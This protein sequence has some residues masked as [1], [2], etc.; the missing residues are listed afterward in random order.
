MIISIENQKGGV[1]KTTIAIHIAQAL[2]MGDSSVL[3]VDAYPQGSAR[4]WAAAR[5][6]EPAFSVIGLDR[7]TLHHDLPAIAANYDH[8]VI[9]GPPRVTDLGGNRRFVQRSAAS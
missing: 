2:A 1:G 5:E 3:L 7:P 4:D 9:D 6:N 8:V